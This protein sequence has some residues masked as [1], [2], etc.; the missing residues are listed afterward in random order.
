MDGN[1]VAP[2]LTITGY[3]IYKDAERNK[4]QHIHVIF[5]NEPYEANNRKTVRPQ[6]GKF[7]NLKP[8]TQLSA[9]FQAASGM[10]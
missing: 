7:N 9:H 2:T 6:N 10:I 1:L 5:D 4:G 3:P 8:G